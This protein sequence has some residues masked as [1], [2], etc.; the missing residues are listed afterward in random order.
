MDAHRRAN[1]DVRNAAGPPHRK[2]PLRRG[3]RVGGQKIHVAAE[4]RIRKE[5]R[6]FQK[7]VQKEAFQNQ[8]FVLEADGTLENVF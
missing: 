8:I 3:H 7:A 6:D 5:R 1:H 4:V 2:P